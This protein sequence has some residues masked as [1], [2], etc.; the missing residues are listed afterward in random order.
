[1]LSAILKLEMTHRSIFLA[2]T[3]K[4]AA[5]ALKSKVPSPAGSQ[6][7]DQSAYIQTKSHLFI[8]LAGFNA[9]LGVFRRFHAQWT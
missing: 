9:F 6:T 3:A 8:I 1:M 5:N 7:A 2:E 4:L